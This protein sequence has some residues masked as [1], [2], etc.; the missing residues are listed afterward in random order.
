MTNWNIN[1]QYSIK[2]YIF[3]GICDTKDFILI[4]WSLS[5]DEYYVCSDLS[6][7]WVLFD[8][9]TNDLKLGTIGLFISRLDTLHLCFVLVDTLEILKETGALL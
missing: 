2:V 5:S 3:N 1:E 9:I 4:E 6:N 7:D 8:V